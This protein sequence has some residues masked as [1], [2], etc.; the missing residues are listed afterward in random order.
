MPAEGGI[1]IAAIPIVQDELLHMYHHGKLHD[2]ME[3]DITMVR[4]FEVATEADHTL[5]CH[6]ELQTALAF[7][8][9]L[10]WMES[11]INSRLCT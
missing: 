9:V 2:A 11:T 3:E 10:R 8:L 5:L 6:V 4:Y 1:H 7:R